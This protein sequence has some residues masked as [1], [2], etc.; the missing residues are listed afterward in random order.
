MQGDN[1]TAESQLAAANSGAVPFSRRLST[2]LLIITALSVLVA[3]VLIFIPSI[4][5]FR[6]RW[7]EERLSTAAAA[8]VLLLGDEQIE[9]PRNVQDDVLLALGAKAVAVRSNGD[10]RLLVVSEIP[11]EVDE[12]IDVMNVGPVDAVVGAVDSMLRGGN[13]VL[14]VFGQVGDSAKEFELIISDRGLRKAMFVYARNV[15]VLSLIISFITAALVFSAIHRF[16][17]Q[18]IRELRGAMVRFGAEPGDPGRILQPSGRSDE[19]GVAEQQLAAMQMQLQRTL[20]EQK[21]LADLGL[22]V[23]KINHDLRNMLASAQLISDR[24]RTANEPS[25]R[26]FAPK[27]VRTLDR[28]VGYT[29]SVLSYG[30]AHEAPPSRRML[31]LRQVVEDVEDLLGIDNSQIVFENLVDTGFEIDADAEQLFRILMN[32][33]RNAVQAMGGDEDA[34]VIRRLTIAA[35]RQ[36]SVSRITVVDTGPGLPDKAREN[37]FAAF[38]GSARSGGTGLGL[39]IAQELVRA[40]GGSIEL[41]ESIG[42]RTVFAIIIPDQ[43]ARL[44][45]ARKALRRPA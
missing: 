8:T 31:K 17:I 22:A 40:H 23:S 24:L 9:L 38:R 32:L 21:H 25:I 12:H 4:A 35:E 42:G 37:L 45:D 27:L 13:R 2:K 5:N 43:P 10:S 15:A 36:G 44:E 39:A 26:V 30:R 7:L 16:L 34:T 11:P 1:I 41:V 29:E 3:E 20:G 18:P 19:L 6:L 28:A 33:G 14:R